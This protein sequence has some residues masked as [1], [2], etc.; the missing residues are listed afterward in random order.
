MSNQNQFITQLKTNLKQFT[1]DIG[2][3]QHSFY[4]QLVYTPG[5]QYL[6]ETAGAYWL[7]DV[8]ASHLNSSAFQ[9]VVQQDRR[10]LDL[11]FWNLTVSDDSSGLVTARVDSGEEA[12]IKQRIPF[13][14]FPLK[15]ID[16]WV[17][18]DGRSLTLY[19]PSEH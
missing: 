10:I 3:Y 13:T 2:R 9:R 14:D 6:A 7:I 1:G 4:P 15:S 18:F 19:L 17:A 5:I 8:I 11:H 12:S 16:L